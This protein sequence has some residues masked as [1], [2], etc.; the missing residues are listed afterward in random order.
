MAV[1]LKVS[2]G[3]P[4][5]EARGRE[6]LLMWEAWDCVCMCTI[7]CREV[8]HHPCALRLNSKRQVH[9]GHRLWAIYLF[10]SYMQVQLSYLILP[11]FSKPAVNGWKL[12]FHIIYSE[13]YEVYLNIMNNFVWKQGQP[14]R[15]NEISHL[16]MFPW[17]LYLCLTFLSSV[18]WIHKLLAM[19]H[20]S[21][22]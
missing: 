18:Q 21:W 13:G 1:H 14:R 19:Q 11:G 9:H 16:K 2:Q 4:P 15:V 17:N 22:K 10:F 12:L 3:E 8:R 5:P 7:T 6:Q 20:V